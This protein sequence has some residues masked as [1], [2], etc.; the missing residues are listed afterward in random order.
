M[1][2]LWMLQVA[3]CECHSGKIGNETKRRRIILTS[4]LERM[5]FRHQHISKTHVRAILNSLSQWENR[6]ARAYK[7][8][9]LCLSWFLPKS[10]DFDRLDEVLMGTRIGATQ[11]QKIQKF[12]GKD[13]IHGRISAQKL[14]R[15]SF[16][17]YCVLEDMPHDDNAISKSHS[18][19][20]V[21]LVLH[22]GRDDGVT[23]ACCI[24]LARLGHDVAILYADVGSGVSLDM[25]H[26]AR[27]V[28]RCGRRA[29]ALPELPFWGATIDTANA[30]VLT[31]ALDTLGGHKGFDVIGNPFSFLP[32][33]QMPRQD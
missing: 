19:R 24:R 30:R 2:N 23:Q 21:A 6:Q 26:A 8:V 15:I 3:D 14:D 25:A 13:A 27:H 22:S 32:L 31:E 9:F 20:R 11:M 33:I 4:Y 16:L 17:K 5:D 7:A 10:Y 18:N 28:E 1:I 29:V 12:V